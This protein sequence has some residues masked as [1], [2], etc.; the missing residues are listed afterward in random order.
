MMG[1]VTIDPRAPETAPDPD[2]GGAPNP[3]ARRATLLLAVVAALVLVSDQVT[4]VIAVARLGDNVPVELFGPVRLV[5]VRNPGAAFSLATSMTWILTLVA[6]G[7]VVIIVRLGRDLVSAPWAVGL[8]LVLGGA[9]GNLGDRFF[10][11]PG[12]LSGHVVDFI[13][14]GWWPVFNIADSGITCGMAIIVVLV[15]RGRQADGT[16]AGEA[17]R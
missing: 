15:L 1:G 3:R 9:L 16:I 13:S 17:R 5:L 2:T 11:A 10:R 7:V 6:V 8:G 4:K 12:P 14:V